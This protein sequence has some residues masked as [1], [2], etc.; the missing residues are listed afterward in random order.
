MRS[1]FAGEEMDRSLA[2]RAPAVILAVMLLADACGDGGT[3]LPSPTTTTEVTR[4]P[5]ASTTTPPPATAPAQ[6]SAAAPTGAGITIPTTTAADEISL[7]VTSPVSRGQAA[8]A[9][10]KTVAGADCTI[11]VTY[12]SGPST[13]EGLGPKTADGAGNVSWSWT[14]PTSAIP[15]SW[16]VEVS[17]STPSGLRAVARLSFTVE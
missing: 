2:Q 13:A 1:A 12:S 16:P 5:P 14:V 15:G 8:I 4:T 7:S 10:A 17:C 3:V 11:T 6:A 9:T